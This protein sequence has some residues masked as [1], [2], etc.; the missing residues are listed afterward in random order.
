MQAKVK[1]VIAK[2]LE[3]FPLI[4]DDPKP[5]IG[6]ESFDS[7][8][9]IVTVRPYINPDDY[10]DATFEALGRIKK[11]FNDAG[12]KVAYSEGVELGKIGD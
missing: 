7:H 2:S 11:G 9:I 8:N 12:I 4:M 3:D 10:W 1:E 5:L 6:I